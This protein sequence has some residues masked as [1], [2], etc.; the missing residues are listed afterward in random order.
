MVQ[1]KLNLSEIYFLGVMT[2]TDNSSEIIASVSPRSLG[3]N[4]LFDETVQITSENV[5]EFSS[6]PSDIRD[7]KNALTRAG[8]TVY[9]EASSEQTVQIGGSAKQFKDFFG[10]KLK[11]QKAEIGPGVEISFMATDEDPEEALLSAPEEF[12]P[13]IE[14]AVIARPPTYFSVSAIPPIADVHPD[15][16]PYFYVPDGISVML[17][18]ARVHRLGV[19]GKGIVV[20]MPDTGMAPHPFYRERGYRIMRTLLVPGASDPSVDLVGHGTGEAANVFACAPDVRLR[21]IKMGNDTVGAI[22]TALNSSPRP[23]ILTN[24]WGYSRD[25]PGQAGHD[26]PKL[27]QTT[28]SGDLQR[29][30]QGHDNLLLGR[31]RAFRFPWESS[32]RHFGWRS[33]CEPAQSGRFRGLK[34]CLELQ[35]DVVSWPVLSGCLRPDRK[36]RQHRW[37]QG[38]QHHVAGAGRRP[39]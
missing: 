19:T 29:R 25:K 3:P 36:A 32:R 22:N 4:S 26:H 7:T 38:A 18:A 35:I 28:R 39:A 33:S 14:G 24:S 6:D 17:R 37:R 11:K 34:L 5:T 13:L 1:Q 8:F 10:A 30:G 31:Q 23:H 15:A 2:M 27:P 12:A 20:G 9:E 21:P 16:Y